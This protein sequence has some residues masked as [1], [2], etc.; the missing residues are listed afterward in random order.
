LSFEDIEEMKRYEFS[1]RSEDPEVFVGLVL[2]TGAQ[3]KALKL[4]I[5][6]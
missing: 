6:F 2:C 4:K 5:K 1:F 3:Q